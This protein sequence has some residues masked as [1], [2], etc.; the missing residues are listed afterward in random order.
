MLYGLALLS[1]PAHAAGEP[2][3]H[4]AEVAQSRVNRLDL[5]KGAELY[6]QNCAACHQPNGQGLPGAFP[7]LAKSDFIA[8]DPG[9]V[10]EVTVKG[11]QGKMVV[12][13]TRRC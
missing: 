9:A 10:L 8:A 7:P 1:L 12:N 5:E 6:Q 13:S 11:M 2:L 3:E 4:K